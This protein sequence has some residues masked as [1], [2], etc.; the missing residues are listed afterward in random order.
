MSHPSCVWSERQRVPEVR[1]RQRSGA[2][3]SCGDPE[4]AP[5][6]AK[7][8][9]SAARSLADQ[10]S[11]SL[12]SGQGHTCGSGGV[13]LARG[14]PSAVSYRTSYGSYCPADIVNSERI[15][16]P[17]CMDSHHLTSIEGYNSS[18]GSVLRCKEDVGNC[19]GGKSGTVRAYLTPPLN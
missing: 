11:P 15:R 13:S 4:L 18:F 7:S 9:S 5:G 17:W 12:C 1:E 16:R 6:P 3:S 14:L 8:E 10:F 19:T 2:D